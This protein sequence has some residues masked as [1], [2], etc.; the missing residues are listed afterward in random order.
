MSVTVVVPTYNEGPNVAELV[1]RL[2]ATLPDGS[3]VLFV[4]DSRDDTPQIISDVAARA[5]LPVRLI[6]RPEAVGGLSGA[7]VEG[8]RAAEAAGTDWVVVMDGDLQHPPELVPALV[9]RGRASD[10]DV[11]VASRYTG[12]GDAGGLD[13]RR[14]KLVS[15]VSGLL[16]RSMFP[17]RLRNVTDPMTGFFALRTGR[18]DLD[19][20][21]PR[22][23]KILLEVL[24][25]T[26]LAVVEEPFVFGE[27]Y[28]GESKASFANGVR[29]VQQLWGLR[30]GRL[31]PFAVI[32][33]LGAVLNLLILW[34]LQS[35]GVHYLPAVIASNGLTIVTNFLLQERFVFRDLRD[36]GSMG[37]RFVQSFA[38]NGTEAVIRTLL[39]WWIVE[40]A[41]PH[42]EL[43]QAGLILVAFLVRFVFHAQVVYKPRRTAPAL[44]EM[45]S[46]DTLRPVR[47][48]RP[49]AEER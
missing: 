11:V 35:A 25:R 33:A 16:A 29:Y 5:P 24:A 30:F 17:V 39:L 4:D 47:P 1:R 45:P 22:G 37:R 46:L 9:E 10:A 44:D 26:R 20:L 7:V 27:R 48:V 28:A 2:A 19:A 36:G 43:V 15:K 23:F 21:R 3:D 38:F 18:V 41:F 14:R 8:L 40:A 12:A 34:A 49:E 13:G 6:H 31:S 42:P 32:G